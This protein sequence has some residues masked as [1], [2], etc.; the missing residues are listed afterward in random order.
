MNDARPGILLLHGLTGNPTV[1][2]GLPSYL[3]ELGYTCETPTLPGHGTTL[4]D[5]EGTTWDNWLTATRRAADELL[6]VAPTIAV[7]GLSM[8]ATLALTLATTAA[9]TRIISLAVIN[10]LICPAPDLQRHLQDL[11]ARGETLLTPFGG[12]IADPTVTAPDYGA[13]PIDCFLSA[14]A[15]VDAL[16]P[17]LITIRTPTLILASRNDDVLDASAGMTL[18]RERLPHSES[19]TFDKGRHLATIDYDKTEIYAAIADHLQRQVDLAG[20]SGLPQ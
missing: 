9:A 19:I 8:G 7:V 20:G 17:A 14:L 6:T 2:G 15:G 5:L 4:D 12:D 1:L 13:V 16:Q 18:L 11:K 3:R 10:P